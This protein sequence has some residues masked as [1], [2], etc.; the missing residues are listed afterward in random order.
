MVTRVD[1]RPFE[2]KG[3]LFNVEMELCK[4]AQL[5]ENKNGGKKNDNF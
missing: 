3:E 4:N 2:R 5:S 1:A